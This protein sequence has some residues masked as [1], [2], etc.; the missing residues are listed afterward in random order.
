MQQAFSENLTITACGAWN[1]SVHGKAE[2]TQNAG[3]AGGS[4]AGRVAGAVAAGA[5]AIALCRGTGVCQGR[6]AGHCRPGA[7]EGAPLG[8][9]GAVRQRHLRAAA[10]GD[11]CPVPDSLPGGRGLSPAASVAGGVA[12]RTGKPPG[13]LAPGAPIRLPRR[14]GAGA[15]RGGEG[16]LPQRHGLSRQGL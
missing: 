8:G 7:G 6:T 3:H 11:L 13:G 2:E 9:G 15:H 5:G 4:S 16:L 14:R 10:H 12:G 1:R